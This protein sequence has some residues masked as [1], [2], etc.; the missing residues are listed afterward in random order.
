MRSSATTRAPK[1]H[2]AVEQPSTGGLQNLP[3]KDTSLPKTKKKPQ[4]DEQDGR[5]G[6][7][8]IKSNPTAAGWVTHKGEDNNMKKFSQGYGFSRGHVWM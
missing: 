2:L 5:T 7:I 3:T 4:Q 1:S 8:V 6:T